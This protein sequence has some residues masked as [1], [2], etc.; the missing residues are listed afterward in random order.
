M[1]GK[2]TIK[3]RNLPL[4]PHIAQQIISVEQVAQV[5]VELRDS[6]QLHGNKLTDVPV[7]CVEG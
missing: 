7:T 1:T 4:D 3:T 5:R 2:V 6:Q